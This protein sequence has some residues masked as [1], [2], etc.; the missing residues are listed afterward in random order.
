MLL[1]Y[2]LFL[3]LGILL[4]IC[5][6]LLPGLHVNTISII[7]LSLFP[8]MGVGALQFA[9]LLASMATV[10]TFLDFIPSIFLGAPEESTAMSILPT[11]RLLLQGRGVEAVK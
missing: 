7:L 5:T 2:L 10:H 3:L 8:F 4:G 11:H 1:E 9:I 6:G